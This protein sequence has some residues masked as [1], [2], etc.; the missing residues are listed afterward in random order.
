MIEDIVLY[1]I[2]FSILCILQSFFIN[3]VYFAFSGGCLNDLE[4]GKICRGNILY[5]IKPSFFERNKD[6]MWSKCCYTC[7]RCMSSTYTIITYWPLVLYLF[8]FHWIEIFVWL[9]N[10]NVICSLNWVIYKKL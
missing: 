9:V 6:K 8:G 3:G 10:V 1:L 4:K 5:S 7:V 2:G